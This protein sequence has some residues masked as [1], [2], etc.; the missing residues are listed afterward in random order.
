VRLSGAFDELDMPGPAMW[1]R[2]SWCALALGFGAIIGLSLPA[3]TAAQ[4]NMFAKPRAAFQLAQVSPL[5]V[6]PTSEKEAIHKAV[7]GYYDA[8]ARS[9]TEA[10]TFYGEPTLL[11]LPNQVTV[12]SKRADVEDF[13]AKLLASL[14]AQ[15][16]SYTK[17]VDPHV[18]LLNATTAIYSTVAVRFKADGTEMQRAGFTYLLRKNN[19][20]WKIHELIATDIDKLL[21][22]D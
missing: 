3:R 6:S 11:V 14:K 20:D 13:L 5:L 8:A 7:S 1:N 4:E 12:L 22:A 21:N 9:A 19:A 16:Y 10:A 15:G 18:K 2:G 17:V